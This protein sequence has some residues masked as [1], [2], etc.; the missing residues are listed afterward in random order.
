MGMIL[1][2][3]FDAEGSNYHMGIV[4]WAVVDKSNVRMSSNFAGTSSLES[5][6][7]SFKWGQYTVRF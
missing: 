7:W 2:G 1:I 6:R 4:V 5:C 3:P